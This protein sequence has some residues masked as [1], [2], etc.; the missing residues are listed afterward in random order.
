MSLIKGIEPKLKSAIDWF[1]GLSSE[2]QTGLVV[3]Y[4]KDSTKLAKDD[5]EKF[6]LIIDEIKINL[7]SKTRNEV[8]GK[9]IGFGFDD[10][11]AGIIVEKIDKND[12][13][14]RTSTYALRD[15][16]DQAFEKLVSEI[17][18]KFFLDW[19]EFT[20]EDVAN[21]CGINVNLVRSAIV[22][23]RDG[24]IW[25]NQR[26]KI[27]LQT[28]LSI[29]ANQY[30]YSQKKISIIQKYLSEYGDDLRFAN[31]FRELGDLGTELTKTTDSLNEI[32][33]KLAEVEALL[34]NQQKK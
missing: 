33:T 1:K 16:P 8:I 14:L 15:I 5:Q 11:L 34:K 24:F 18:C 30:G 27:S 12:P 6:S 17:I 13:N 26:G 25:S 3:E 9:L 4:F 20:H 2:K 7:A 22:V 29:L 28:F 19:N 23:F 21:K 31:I 10:T 32:K